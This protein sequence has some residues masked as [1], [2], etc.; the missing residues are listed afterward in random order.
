[1]DDLR[2]RPAR[3]DE[4]PQLSA[5]ADRAKAGWGYPA[6]WLAEWRPL[7]T[8]TAADVARW[9]VFVGEAGGGR[10][11]GFYALAPGGATGA[12]AW[13]LEHLWVEP[14]EQRRGWGR[15]LLAHALAEARGAGAT[16]LRIEADPH[17]LAFYTRAGAREVGER[18]TTV[19][20]Q[21]RRLP[22]L[23]IAVPGPPVEQPVSRRPRG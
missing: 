17:A 13:T 10:V 6:A 20:G 15:R 4:A 16:C 2:I 8:L 9:R 19:A 21:A 14:V 22:V 12:A 11:A 3:A 1:M 18:R 7:L 23:E 5:L